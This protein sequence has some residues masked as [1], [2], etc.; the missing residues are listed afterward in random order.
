MKKMFHRWLM[1]AWLRKIFRKPGNFQKS[2]NSNLF[3]RRNKHH[4]TNSMLELKQATSTL[5]NAPSSISIRHPQLAKSA[6]KVASWMQNSKFWK[7]QFLNF[8]IRLIESSVQKESS[9][10]PYYQTFLWSHTL[11]HALSNAL[12]I[13]FMRHP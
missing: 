12:S 9:S 5:S 2:W 7:S 10:H 6:P 1:D 4:D 3:S 13:T 8:L 11:G